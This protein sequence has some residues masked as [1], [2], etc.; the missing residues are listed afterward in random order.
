MYRIF[1]GNESENIGIK[2]GS[3]LTQD[4]YDLLI[5]YLDQTQ[6]EVGPLRLLCDFSDCDGRNGHALW[7]DLTSQLH[8]F[9]EIP[10]V[11][12][13]GDRQWIGCSTKVLHPLLQT[14][15]NTLCRINWMRHGS[16]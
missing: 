14:T 15:V 12:V 5:P 1:N 16:G 4:D 10:R 2:I 13:V 9:H 8:R 11:A 7:K 6:Q 3:Q